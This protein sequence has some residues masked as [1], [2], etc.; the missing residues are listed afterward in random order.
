MRQDKIK[1][2]AGMLFPQHVH[3]SN[4]STFKLLFDEIRDRFWAFLK[5]LII[6][7]NEGTIFKN[8]SLKIYKPISLS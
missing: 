1:I 5:I 4:K 8:Y 3:S 7:D 6:Q 2:F